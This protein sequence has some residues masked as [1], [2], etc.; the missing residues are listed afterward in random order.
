MNRRDFL[1]KGAGGS[2]AFALSGLIMAPVNV[3]AATATRTYDIS[4][5]SQDTT[6][7]DGSTVFTWSL[8]DPASPGPGHV[9]SGMVVTEGDTIEVNLTN[10]L[11]RDINFVV[12]GVLG[13]TPTVAPGET[14]TYTFTAPAAGTYMYTDDANGYIAKAMGLFGALVVNPADGSAALYENG[15]T[16]DQQ[17]VMV[18]SDMDGRLNDAIKNGATSYDINNYEP[19]YYFANGLIY[20]DTKKYDDTLI[21][22]NVGEDVAI[23]FINAGVIEYPM[24]FHGYHVNAIK[25]NRQLVSGFISRDTV[26]V[27]PDTTA[28]VILPVEQSGAYPLHTHY[29]P[30]VTVNGV[31]TNPYGGGLIIM[32]AS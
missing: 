12:Q 10:N 1:R 9:G 22:M 19:N 11:D 16:Y 3:Q 29:V 23:R 2:I 14:K 28:E 27:R 25:N 21:T 7:I 8:D 5:N 24:H 4:A 15:P 6:M 31:Y 26:L 20:P 13:S 32:V 18:M 17:Y 30:G